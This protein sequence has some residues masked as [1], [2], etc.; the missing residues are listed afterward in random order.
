MKITDTQLKNISV[1]DLNEYE[2]K[3]GVQNI[4][5]HRGELQKILANEIGYEN[6]N[7]SKRLSKI[8]KDEFF[9]LTFEDNSPI[10]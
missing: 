8:E 10:E 7:L 5:I 9:K 2:K 1:V 4:A 6:I 3:Y